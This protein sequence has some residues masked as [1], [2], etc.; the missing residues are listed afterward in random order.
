MTGSEFQIVLSVTFYTDFHHFLRDFDY[1][2]VFKL[3]LAMRIE[4]IF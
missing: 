3:V 2:V 1:S 4:V